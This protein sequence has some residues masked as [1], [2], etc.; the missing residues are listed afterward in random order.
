MAE[1]AVR[2]FA[3]GVR[4][5]RSNLRESVSTHVFYQVTNDRVVEVINVSPFYVLKT[6]QTDKT[7]SM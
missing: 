5:Y 6:E 4:L 7:K 1:T 3:C 2:P